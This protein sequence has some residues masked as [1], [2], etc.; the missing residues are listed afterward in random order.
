[1]KGC[2]EHSTEPSGSIR[3]W[4]SSGTTKLVNSQ[5][6]TRAMKVIT[7]SGNETGHL[8]VPV[9]AVTSDQRLLRASATSSLRIHVSEKAA[10]RETQEHFCSN[11]PEKLDHRCKVC[12][13]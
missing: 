4:D 11:I 1:M 12:S 8:L 2:W 10:K 6:G 9:A 3:H 7:R 13:S 5:E